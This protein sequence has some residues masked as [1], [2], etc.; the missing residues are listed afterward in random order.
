MGGAIYWQRKMRGGAIYWHTSSFS[1]QTS[2][3]HDRLLDGNH[4]TTDSS[5]I[6]RRAN[7]SI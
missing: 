6:G 7:S 1:I 4:S 2:V 3:H 5:I